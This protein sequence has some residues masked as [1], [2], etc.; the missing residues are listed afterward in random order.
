MF[1]PDFTGIT[2]KLEQKEGV[3]RVLDPIRKRWIVLTPEE[4][5]RQ[6][7]LHYL[8]HQLQYPQSLI[9]VEK[10]IKVGNLLKRFDL[11]VFDRNHRPW[12]LAEC[13]APEIDITE[14]TLYQLLQYQQTIQSRYWLLTNGRQFYCADAHEPENIVWLNSLPIYGG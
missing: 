3:T 8:I 12:L 1:V 4:H 2:L 5:V 13:K 11:V 7:L 14:R 6:Y 9:A 10:T